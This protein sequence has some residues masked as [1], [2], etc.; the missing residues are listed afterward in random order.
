MRELGKFGR[1]S[2][3]SLCASLC[4][5]CDTVPL[6]RFLVNRTEQGEMR[7]GKGEQPTR[8][9]SDA[10]KKSGRD[11]RGRFAVGVSGNP[12]GKLPPHPR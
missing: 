11:P 1:T 4:T 3:A 2:C 12:R 9:Q 10:E 8:A 5:L 7:K 6:S